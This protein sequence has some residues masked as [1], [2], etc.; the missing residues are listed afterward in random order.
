M[1]PHDRAV[2]PGM[3]G[4]LYLNVFGGNIAPA[5]ERGEWPVQ[6]HPLILFN[7]TNKE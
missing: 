7:E 3:G 4:D 6:T 2:N 5:V 1:F